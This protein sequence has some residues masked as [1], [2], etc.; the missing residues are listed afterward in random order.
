[1]HSVAQRR[2][3]RMTELNAVLHNLAKE[4]GA[5]EPYQNVESLEDS[6]LAISLRELLLSQQELSETGI[7]LPWTHLDK[8]TKEQPPW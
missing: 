6:V 7:A 4:Q 2:L 1:M 5:Q 8:S 3:A